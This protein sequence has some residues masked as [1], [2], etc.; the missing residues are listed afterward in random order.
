MGSDS[1]GSEGGEGAEDQDFDDW[2][3]EGDGEPATS[4]LCA[5]TF[6]SPEAA[7]DYDGATYGF[8]LRAF[9]AKERLDEYDIFRCINYVREEVAAGRDPLPALKAGDTSAWRGDDALLKPVLSDDALLF[10]DYE[11]VV[12]AWQQS[13]AAAGP[14]GA[15]SSDAAAAQQSAQELRR[16]H[17]ENDAL[18]DALSMM[19]AACMPDELRAEKAYMAGAGAAAAGRGGLAAGGGGGASTSDPSAA[20]GSGSRTGGSRR[21]RSAAAAP[22]GAKEMSE[23]AKAVD[24]NYF[25]SY[26]GFGIHEEMISDRARTDAYQT[27]LERNPAL[28]SGKTVLDV[29]CGTGILSL[30]ACRAGAARVVSVDGNARIAGFA[31]QVCA[32]NGYAHESGGPMSVHTGKVEELELPVE[33]VDVLVS[34]W[35]GYALLFETMLDSV[36]AARDK[37]LKPG[38]A[39]LPDIARIFVAGGARGATDAAFW[40]DVY[41]FDMR[42]IG[43]EVRAGEASSAGVRVVR[44][45]DVVTGDVEVKALDLCSMAPDDQDFTAEFTLVAKPPA[46]DAGDGSAGSASASGQGE[47]SAAAS[48]ADGGVD[49]YAVVLWFDTEFSARHCAEAPVT[50]STSW[51]ATTTHWAQ[52]VLALR[53]PV[54]LA[55][56]GSAPGPSSA[57]CAPCIKGRLSMVR[58]RH[59]HR[60]LDISLEYSAQLSDGTTVSHTSLYSMS[61]SSGDVKEK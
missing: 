32:A 6:D 48:A 58:N 10:Y 12:V 37:Y 27:A 13:A 19:A 20:P 46:A 36:L 52:T 43:G 25:D 49:V 44:A 1:E 35:M 26:G 16:L 17:D 18:R 50:L 54:R 51:A 7:M 4:L 47:A 34:E 8:D 45:R 28:V 42:A 53:T 38:G 57:P 60:F 61:V 23:G 33:Q 56:P 9:A 55:L 22:G 11:E 24:G 21:G 40:S 41:G 59:K 39:M 30:F 31:R 14:S 3:E 5:K 2:A 15:A 29:G